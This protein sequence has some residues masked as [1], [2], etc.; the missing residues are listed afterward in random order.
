MS[1]K[2]DWIGEVNQGWEKEWG[3]RDGIQGGSAK[4]N[5]FEKCLIEQNHSKICTYMMVI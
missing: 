5:S 2:W 3:V 4:T 1:E